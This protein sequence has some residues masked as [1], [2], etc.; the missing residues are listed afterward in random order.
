MACLKNVAIAFASCRDAMSRT[1]QSWNC[2]HQRMRAGIA[3]GLRM[4]RL[5]IGD[6]HV[7]V[8]IDDDDLISRII[9]WGLHSHIDRRNTLRIMGNHLPRIALL[10]PP[11]SLQWSCR[12]ITILSIT[13]LPTNKKTQFSGLE[14]KCRATFG[15]PSTPTD[16][17]PRPRHLL[18]SIAP[19][20]FLEVDPLK[21][22]A[23]RHTANASSR[24]LLDCSCPARYLLGVP[25]VVPTGTLSERV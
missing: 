11:P 4:V 19:L 20:L 8:L 21:D 2:S 1:K 18:V 16:R 22:F 5:H 6:C 9:I 12:K 24:G 17:W 14:K 25:S 15:K 7:R 23:H 3:H 13:G 10:L